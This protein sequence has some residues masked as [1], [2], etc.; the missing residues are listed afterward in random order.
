MRS[1]EERAYLDQPIAGAQLIG[2]I[3][4]LE[5]VA[6]IIRYQHKRYDGSGPPDDGLAGE[7]IPLGAR[8]L[9]A[10]L[11]FDTLT[12]RGLDEAEALAEM[13]RTGQR[14]DPAVLRALAATLHRS[15]HHAEQLRLRA[16]Q[17][18]DGM[19]V[20]SDVYCEQGLL[21]VCRGQEV[22]RAGRRYLTRFQE[23]GPLPGLVS[24]SKPG[25]G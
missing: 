15:E 7:Q 24:V 22:T 8:I 23:A 25:P 6:Q 14:F 1:S 11:A 10:V 17:L 2:D 20:E 21:L 12:A 13:E 16:D 4:R 18:L 3:P 19:V 9:Q 5:G